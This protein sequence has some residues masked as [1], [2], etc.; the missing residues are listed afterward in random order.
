MPLYR[1]YRIVSSAGEECYIG[2]TTQPLWKRYSGH[3]TDHKRGRGIASCAIFTKY[4]VDTCSIVLISEQEMEKAE[5]MREERRLIEECPMAMNKLRP[6]RE[7]EEATQ[8]N[9]EW[10]RKWHEEHREEM[11]E[12]H[13]TYYEEHREEVKER[14]RNY[15]EEHREAIKAYQV[16]KNPCDVCGKTVSRV[17]MT[18]HKRTKSCQASK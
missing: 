9:K 16:E 18:K 6:I 3:K 13:R 1:F 17:N 5:A 12:R 10:H 14:V 4:G 8:E 11:K 2:S 7:R 15:R